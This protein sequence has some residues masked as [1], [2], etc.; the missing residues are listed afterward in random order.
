MSA[1]M[2]VLRFWRKNN[3]VALWK[4]YDIFQIQ[5]T[6]CV[7]A[8]KKF[9]LDEKKATAAAIAATNK[10][11]N[12]NRALSEAEKIVG[13]PTSF[14]SLRWLLSDEIA[15]I[16][17]HLRKLVGSNHPL[18]QTA[19]NIVFNGHN[20]IQ[21]FG[22]IVLLISKAAG[23]LHVNHIEEDKSAGVLH[24]QRALAEI[25]EMIRTS[26]L[27][28]KGLVNINA[29]SPLGAA[30]MDR[31]TFGN[32]IALLSGDYLLSNSCVELAGLRNQDVVFLISSAVADIAQA[33][34]VARRDD[35]NF[36]IPSIPPE[37]DCTGYALKEWELLNIYGAG[38]LLAKS[39]QSTLK[40]AGHSMEIQQEGYKFGQHL[41]LAWQAYLD[42]ALCVN[43][44]E[45][46]L[47]N[48]CAAPIMFHVEHDPSILVELEKGLKSVENVDYLK[49]L[50]IVTA[51][52]GIE[53]T[54]E[55]VKEHS[56]RAMEVLNVFKE[57]D[58]RKALSN[59]ISAIDVCHSNV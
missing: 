24:S 7:S 31:M 26:S 22:L 17:L 39:C 55:L 10:K 32:K 45:T 6:I 16:A 25:T 43:K 54:K 57:N 38:S 23:H 21:A 37:G 11:L 18:L 28:H 33:E 49:V 3:P 35:Q 13:Y 50:E 12:W 34:F 14:L 4:S 5:R 47:H 29:D 15:N 59:I 19:K 58:A 56:R 8:Q 52:P 20:N 51:G 40:L 2:A 9:L 48:L 41:S 36:P 44:D 42:L 46:I 53:L 30:E 27:I 1:N